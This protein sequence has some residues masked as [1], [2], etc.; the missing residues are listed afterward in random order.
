M[1]P[2]S[3]SQPAAS[4]IPPQQEPDADDVTS[5]SF[6]GVCSTTTVKVKR[7]ESGV[8]SKDLAPRR[9]ALGHIAE[10]IG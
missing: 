9:R 2:E 1:L 3:K 5:S 7:A 10:P 6:D 4:E 8:P